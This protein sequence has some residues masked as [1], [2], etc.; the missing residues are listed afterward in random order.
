MGSIVVVVF[1]CT[2]TRCVVVVP[3]LCSNTNRKSD[4]WFI[5]KNAE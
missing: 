3:V 4:V 2:R 5:T 1:W